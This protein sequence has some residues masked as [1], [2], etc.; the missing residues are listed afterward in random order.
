VIFFARYEASQAGSP[1]IETEQLLFGLFRADRATLSTCLGQKIEEA[2]LRLEVITQTEPRS[3]FSTSVDLPI[4][5][6]CQRILAY[7]DEEAQ[8]L[9]TYIG[10]E[11]LLLGILRE[12][13]CLAARLLS[14]RGISLEQVRA[15]ISASASERPAVKSFGSGSSGVRRET[16]SARSIQFV[17]EAGENLLTAASLGLL[18]RIGEAVTILVEG[19]PRRYRVLDV[20]WSFANATAD[21]AQP[22][23]ILRLG[24]LG[25]TA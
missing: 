22:E 6:E 23:I 8:G 3:P 16:P 7:A 1:Y 20:E 2:E 13:N 19:S 12:E 11:H 24:W 25:A 10:T 9:G 4:S 18:P 5:D 17:D 14:A 21:A 15:R